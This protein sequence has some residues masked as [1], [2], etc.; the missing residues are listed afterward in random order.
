M[1]IV[2]IVTLVSQ[3]WPYVKPYEIVYFKMCSV[4]NLN[5]SFIKLLKFCGRLE[6]RSGTGHF[7]GT[8]K[9]MG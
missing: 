2:L 8:K 9:G 4:L 1:F 5:Y 3:V 7:V 6:S